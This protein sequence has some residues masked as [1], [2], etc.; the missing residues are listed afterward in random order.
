VAIVTGGGWNIGRAIASAFAAEGARIVVASRRR[1]NLDE[2]VRLISSA[3][4]EAVAVPTDVTDLRQV[5]ALVRTAVARYGTVDIMAAIAGGGC[6]DEAVDAIDPDAWERTLRTNLLS[7][8]YSARA[9]LPVLRKQDRGD[10]LTCSGGGAYFAVLGTHSTAYACAKAAVCRFTDQ[11]T[12]ELLDTPIRV[13]CLDPGMVPDPDRLAAI[14]AEERRTGGPVADAEHRRRPEDAAEL[15]VW[16]VSEQSRPLRG[17][18][19]SVY[20]TW[21]RD[22][23]RVTQVEQSVQACRLRRSDPV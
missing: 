3:G 5:E 16:L 15:A 18:L 17:R 21:W 1:E 7:T 9:V 23:Q 14:E 12:A 13:N 10:I 8:F 2:T 11:L 4:G 19:V 22:K 6:T 20:D